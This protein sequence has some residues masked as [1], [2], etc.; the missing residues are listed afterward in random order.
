MLSLPHGSS[1]LPVTPVLGD[2]MPSG[3]CGHQACRWCGTQ[4]QCRQNAH[5]QSSISTY[6]QVIQFTIQTVKFKHFYY[7]Q[8]QPN[9]EITISEHFCHIKRR[10]LY[11]VQHLPFPPELLA[12]G[13]PDNILFF[14]DMP[15]GCLGQQ[16]HNRMCFRFIHVFV[17]RKKY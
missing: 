6:C 13:K 12:P 14:T 9:S 8:S 10:F 3:F 16:N 17:I 1:P 5:T 7:V 11:S 4:T 15:Y 2:L